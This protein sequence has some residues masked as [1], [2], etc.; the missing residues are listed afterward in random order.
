M[1]Q[2]IQEVPGDVL[3]PLG[4]RRQQLRVVPEVFRQG[5]VAADELAEAE[6]RR[7]RIAELV[8]DSRR[9]PA[10]HLHLLRCDHLR[11]EAVLVR[12]VADAGQQ[13]R[14]P[15]HQQQGGLVLRREPTAIATDPGCAGAERFPDLQPGEP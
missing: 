7:Q 11:L 15:L 13:S 2:E 3:G 6:D 5:R 9:Q 10:G 8:S 12:Q 14:F 1:G 4:F